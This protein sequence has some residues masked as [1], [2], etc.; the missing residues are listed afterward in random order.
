LLTKYRDH[1]YI[2]CKT[3]GFYLVIGI[4]VKEGDWSLASI[5]FKGVHHYDTLYED[6]AGDQPWLNRG[7]SIWI[8]PWSESLP[9]KQLLD[10]SLARKAL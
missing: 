7:V 9:G 5:A 3:S 4:K 2:R 6:P 1:V 8:N 10:Q